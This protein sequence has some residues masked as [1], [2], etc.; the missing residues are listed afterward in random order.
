MKNREELIKKLALLEIR[1]RIYFENREYC[2]EKM[3]N[4][5][6]NAYENGNGGSSGE[7][8]RRSAQR[9][10]HKYE[11][12]LDKIFKLVRSCGLKKEHLYMKEYLQ[13]PEISQMIK[14][15]VDKKQILEAVMEDYER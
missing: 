9:W 13:K 1:C 5:Y 3:V 15:D 6:E 7:G 11:K 8:W 10:G 4:A 12:M 2:L 14:E